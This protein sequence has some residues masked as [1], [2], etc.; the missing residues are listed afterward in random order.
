MKPMKSVARFAI[1]ALLL[2][3][4]SGATLVVAIVAASQLFADE[5]LQYFVFGYAIAIHN[6]L[7]RWIWKQLRSEKTATT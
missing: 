1:E 3:L 2:F 7:V 5:K 6:D 4:L